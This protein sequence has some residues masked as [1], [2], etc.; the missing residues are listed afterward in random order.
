MHCICESRAWMGESSKGQALP[1]SHLGL[2][3]VKVHFLELSFWTSLL[4][5]TINS[6]HEYLA[7][8]ITCFH[9]LPA[10]YDSS[11]WIN[12]SGFVKYSVSVIRTLERANQL[13][14]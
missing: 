14:R 13:L 8:S 7:V 4:H 1:S 10:N 2:P 9:V 11:Y 12:T 6:A 3:R 5:C